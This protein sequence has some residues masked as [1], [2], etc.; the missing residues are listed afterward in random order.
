V[1]YVVDDDPVLCGALQRRLELAGYQSVTCYSAQSFLD[2]ADLDRPGC[3]VLDVNMPELDGLALQQELNT[4]GIHMPIIFITGYGD[5]PMSVQ[6]MKEGAVD[7]LTKPVDRED[8]LQA[9]KEALRQEEAQ[10]QEQAVL[11]RLQQRYDSLTPRERQVFHLVVTGLP[12]KQTAFQ[13]GITERTVKVHR[14]N[15]MRKMEA[16]SIAELV[17]QSETLKAMQP[18]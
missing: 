14:S 4:R 7:F 11:S 10:R 16:H 18:T 3:L 15:V 9:V 17:R 12:N 6:A 2:C 5:I 1:I 8:L 13:L